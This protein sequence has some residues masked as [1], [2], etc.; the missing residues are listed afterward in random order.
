LILPA[1]SSAG[2]RP[3]ERHSDMSGQ[4]SLERDIADW[5][6]RSRGIEQWNSGIEPDRPE[7]CCGGTFAMLFEI[8]GEAVDDSR[9]SGATVGDFEDDEP[10]P[11]Q[12]AI[13]RLCPNTHARFS[14]PLGA[15]TPRI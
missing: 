5:H 7:E 12:A 2:Y 15:Q 11:E 14:L 13:P 10:S 1:C 9:A 8:C 6:Q 3:H 4:R